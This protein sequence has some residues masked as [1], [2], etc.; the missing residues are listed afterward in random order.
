MVE[1]ITYNRRNGV[2]VNS[3]DLAKNLGADFE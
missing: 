2:V 3:T 1:L